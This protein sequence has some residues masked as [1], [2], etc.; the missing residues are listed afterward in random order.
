MI[1]QQRNPAGGSQLVEGRDEPGVLRRVVNHDD[2]LML[3]DGGQYGID[4]SERLLPTAVHGNED[5]DRRAGRR[6]STPHAHGRRHLLSPARKPG[7]LRICESQRATQQQRRVRQRLPA[8]VGQLGRDA[9]AAARQ[10]G[11][12]RFDLERPATPRMS[13]AFCSRSMAVSILI[14]EA[15]L[16]RLCG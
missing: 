4:A 3:S 15:E 2:P 1:T 7:P 14:L 8:S 5:V 12:A 6:R 13:D 16:Y 11:A 10:A 9:Y